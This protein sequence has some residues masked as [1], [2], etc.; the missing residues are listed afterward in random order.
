MLARERALEMA[1]AEAARHV[2]EEGGANTGPRVQQYQAASSLAGTGW[3]WCDAFCDF[4]FA[5]AGRPLDELARSA[6]VELTFERAQK[7]GWLVAAPARGDLVC[8]QW[9]SGALDHIGFVVQPE[10]DGSIKTVE[11]NTEAMPGTGHTQ[12]EGDGV[13][14]KIRPR[15]VCAA[16]IRVPGEVPAPAPAAGFDDWA[17]WVEG[18]RKGKRPSVPERVP[19]AWWAKLGDALEAQPDPHP[20]HGVQVA[21]HA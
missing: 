10:P 5:E 9:D 12:G 11:G 17:E 3:P 15:H 4:C 2:H 1:L 6:G 19:Q 20:P 13:Y 16:F 14:V 18:G 7:N 21:T 8:F